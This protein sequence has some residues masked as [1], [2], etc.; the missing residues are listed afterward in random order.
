VALPLVLE[1]NPS[2]LPVENVDQFIAHARA[3]PGKI[4]IASFGAGTIG[5]L[6]IE[7]FKSMTGVNIVHVPY[8][9]GAPLA[10]D[11]LAG[12]VQA[13][14]DALPSSLP[15][16]RTGALRALALT[17]RTSA[18]PGVPSIGETLPGYEVSPWLGVGVP[19]NTPPEIIDRLNREI[20]T[21]LA[22]AGIKARL[23]EFG[24]SPT[25]LSPAEFAA[26]VAAETEKWAKVVRLSGVKAN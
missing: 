21:A 13:G 1:V 12:Q 2:S 18:L 15:H 25:L 11:L 3:N 20:N 16:I 24:G 23:A 19:R 22:D 26:Y 4:N 6:A 5:H 10:T 9:G 17:T 8:R 14:F 7:L